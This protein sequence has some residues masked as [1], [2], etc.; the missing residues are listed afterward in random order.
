MLYS[1]ALQLS[2][3]TLKNV[4][5]ASFM[6]SISHNAT[7]SQALCIASCAKPMSQVFMPSVLDV[8]SPS[9]LPQRT[10]LLL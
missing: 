4:V 10:A 7:V 9:V 1:V 3:A 8:T 6:Y 2:K 5:S